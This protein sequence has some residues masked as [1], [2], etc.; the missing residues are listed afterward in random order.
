[1]AEVIV[2]CGANLDVKGMPAGRFVQHTSNPGH[3]VTTVGGVARN[4]AANLAHLDVRTA[5]ISAVGSDEAGR[6]ILDVTR[7]TGVDVAMVK[8]VEGASGSYLAVLDDRGELI[9]A[10][11]D[12]TCLE[13]LT[14]AD[15]EAQARRLGAASLIAADC[16][17]AVE[18]LDWLFAFADEN[19]IRLL[20]EPVS[21]PKAQKLKRLKRGGRAFAI[22]PN[23]DQ[24]TALTGGMADDP[25]AIA[26]LHAMGYANVVV[27]RG[28]AGAIVSDGVARSIV[29]PAQTVGPVADVTGAG[30]AAVAGL[31]CGVLEG[32]DLASSAR[33]GQVAAAIKIASSAPVSPGLN[34]VSLFSLAGIP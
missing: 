34:R 3:V 20:I 21:V 11:S 18:C 31:I 29:I 2:I 6:R 5:L 22:T 14:A 7:E 9:A 24:F 1:M 16:N 17:L 23:A 19:R 28:A 27:H 26:A 8:R 4:I 15:L 25:G 33:L 13:A 30:D 12:M 10:I 32:C